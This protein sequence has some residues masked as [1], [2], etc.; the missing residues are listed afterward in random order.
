M[1]CVLRPNAPKWDV[2]TPEWNLIMLFDKL[3]QFV[4]QK[5]PLKQLST[6]AVGLKPAL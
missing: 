6:R 4:T 3:I 1:V 5:D 2:I